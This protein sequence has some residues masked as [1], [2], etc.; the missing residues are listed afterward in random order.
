MLTGTTLF[1]VKMKVQYSIFYIYIYII[2]D[3]WQSTCIIRWIENSPACVAT[4]S[5]SLLAQPFVTST[6]FCS[7]VTHIPESI[8]STTSSSFLWH[9][10]ESRSFL[11]MLIQNWI[12]TGWPS[13][14]ICILCICG[15]LSSLFDWLEK[16]PWLVHVWRWNFDTAWTCH[17]S[18][19]QLVTGQ[20]FSSVRFQ[21][22]WFILLPFWYDGCK[23]S[24]NN[25]QKLYNNV[26]LKV[27]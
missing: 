3:G 8:L 6:M 17:W 27:I 5:S 9:R 12:S 19:S 10:I 23:C 2:I 24:L 7:V 1:N 11:V 15:L 26:I 16:W 21:I 20:S 22:E 14:P 25:I 13:S 4:C 18:W